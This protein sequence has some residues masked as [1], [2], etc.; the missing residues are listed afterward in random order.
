MIQSIWKLHLTEGET[1]EVPY[2]GTIT[3]PTSGPYTVTVYDDSGVT[4]S[5]DWDDEVLEWEAKEIDGCDEDF[6]RSIST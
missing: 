3:V 6:M 4:V 2:I 5:Q 1:V